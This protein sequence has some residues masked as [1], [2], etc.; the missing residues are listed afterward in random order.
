MVLLVL[1]GSGVAIKGEDLAVG[2]QLWNQK[3]EESNQKD[4]FRSDSDGQQE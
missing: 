3:T 2:S 4:S 1:K